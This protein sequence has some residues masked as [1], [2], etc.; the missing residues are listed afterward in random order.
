MEIV[1]R[2]CQT[3]MQKQRFVTAFHRNAL[4][5]RTIVFLI[6]LLQ[7]GPMRAAEAKIWEEF[8]GDKAFALVQRLVDFGPRP[9]G[10]DALEK[11]RTY[12]EEQLRLYGWNTRRQAYTEDT[13]RGKTHFVNLIAQFGTQ[14]KA[15]SP[16][17][18][19]CTH[20]DTKVFDTISFVGANDGGSST[21]LVLELARVIGQHPTLA[22]KV[23]LVFFDGEEA[24]EQFSDTDGLY[25]SRYFARQLQG[26]GAKQFRGGLLFDMVGDRSLGITLPNDSPAD[27]AR[28]IFAAAE[29]L[30]LRSYFTYLGRDLIDDHVPLNGI[31]IPTL[32][33]IDFDYPWWHTAD[34]TTDKISARSLQIVGSI[35]LYYL[36]EIALK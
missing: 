19:L 22:S 27:M 23:E 32:D 30:K 5:N 36:S 31:G 9:A 21:G 17:F 6:S 33:V 13:P 10:S 7:T 29:A 1:G 18:L 15:A 24:F 8:S 3:P 26:S 2:L 11:S 12:I 34:D 4:R 35:A 16:V 14:K 25:G 20:Y 28:D